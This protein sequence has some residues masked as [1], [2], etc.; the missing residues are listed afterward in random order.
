MNLGSIFE[1][2]EVKEIMASPANTASKLFAVLCAICEDVFPDKQTRRASITGLS[3]GGNNFRNLLAARPLAWEF[4]DLVNLDLSNNNIQTSTDLNAFLKCK[5]VEHILLAGN[6]WLQHPDFK[7]NILR[8]YPNLKFVDGVEVTAADRESVVTHYVVPATLA[9]AYDDMTGI[10]QKFFQNFFLGFDSDRKA[11]VDY[12]Y[13]KNSTF[14]Y[15]VNTRSLKDPDSKVQTE[16][17]EWEAWLYHSRNLMKITHSHARE[18]RKQ[19]G[20]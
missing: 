19:K 3:L 7:Q 16:K 4:P 14:S 20:K 17:G 12:Y 13:D 9:G 1:E 10:G 2:P 18:S 8:A 5:R 15:N 6:P 11:L